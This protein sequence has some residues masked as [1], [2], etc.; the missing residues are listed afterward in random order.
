M[1][2]LDI[3]AGMLKAGVILLCIEGMINVLTDLI[4]L[5]LEVMYKDQSGQSIRDIHTSVY[6]DCFTILRSGFTKED[7]A[8]LI[9]GDLSSAYFLLPFTNEA[10]LRES[11]A[12]LLKRLDFLKEKVSI[13]INYLVSAGRSNREKVMN[14][15]AFRQTII[16]LMT[17][18]YVQFRILRYDHFV[19]EVLDRNSTI[20]EIYNIN[21][22]FQCYYLLA[23][24]WKNNGEDNSNIVQERDNE[25]WLKTYLRLLW[26][27]KFKWFHCRRKSK[28]SL[29]CRYKY[30]IITE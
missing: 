23:R 11:E 18:N 22:G 3:M 5:L 17:L 1:I 6:D 16:S 28:C 2:L 10:G 20:S 12:K 29:K 26:G 19:P 9:K 30:D 21:I 25:A 24:L 4:D 13:M 15:G 7:Q 8:F 14:K 27:L